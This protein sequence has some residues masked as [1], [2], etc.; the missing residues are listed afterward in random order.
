[1]ELL[2]NTICKP[3]LRRLGTFAGATMLG[4]GA[5]AELALQVELI[6]AA[7][8][9]FGWDLLLSNINRKDVL[10]NWGR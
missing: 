6:V 1:M 10:K 5:N 8:A 9:A 3:I 7:L 2:F 4:L